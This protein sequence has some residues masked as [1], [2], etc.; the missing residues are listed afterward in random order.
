[1]FEQQL[2]TI[3]THWHYNTLT[4]TYVSTF[5]DK[6]MKTEGGVEGERE[7]GESGI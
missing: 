5:H 2:K 7:Q 1:V 3:I 6:M 4:T